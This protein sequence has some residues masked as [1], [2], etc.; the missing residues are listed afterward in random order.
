MQQVM[1]SR[2]AGCKQVSGSADVNSC[3]D[4]NEKGVTECIAGESTACYVYQR[5]HET[6]CNKMECHAYE[7]SFLPQFL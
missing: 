2:L 4:P 6:I 1:A 7:K 5:Q 3:I